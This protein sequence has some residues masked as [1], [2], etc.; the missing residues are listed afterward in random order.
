MKELILP[1]LF[2]Y[3]AVVVN[4]AI[5]LVAPLNPIHLVNDDVDDFG[6]PG[7]LFPSL[8]VVFMV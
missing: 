8:S 4:L 5:K 7:R 6:M 2:P 1:F 3:S